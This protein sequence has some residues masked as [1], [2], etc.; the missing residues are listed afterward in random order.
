MVGKELLGVSIRNVIDVSEVGGP[1]RFG[2]PV[3]RCADRLAARIC[4]REQNAELDTIRARGCERLN[5]TG[6]RL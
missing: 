1:A 4:E 3:R 6:D 5:E 2:V